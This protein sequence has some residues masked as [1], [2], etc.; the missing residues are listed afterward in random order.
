MT[1]QDILNKQA[2]RGLDQ[3][4][5][6]KVLKWRIAE[7]KLVGGDKIPNQKEVYGIP[8]GDFS[9]RLV[10]HYSTKIDAALTIFEEK[11]WWSHH[12]SN[13]GGYLCKIT[14]QKNE[15]LGVVAAETLPLAICRAAL[16]A[17]LRSN[18]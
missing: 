13:S 7:W 15:L 8:L 16:L 5:A 10:P 17:V 9:L 11:E 18:K 1:E 14:S 4:V 3:W 2:G 6:E 12:A